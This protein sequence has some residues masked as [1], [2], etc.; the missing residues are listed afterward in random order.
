LDFVGV[1]VVVWISFL[2]DLSFGNLSLV[3]GLEGVG[4]EIESL[5]LWPCFDS[6]VVAL[7]LVVS[8]IFLL[9]LITLVSEIVREWPL[10]GW[11]TSGFKSNFSISKF[12]SSVV[13]GLLACLV[14]VVTL[15][16]AVL[17]KSSFSL[18]SNFSSFGSV[19]SFFRF[20]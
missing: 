16:A 1:L 13:E 6:L 18:V 15:G 2:S 9:I 8:S 11:V 17:F 4:F 14:F 20:L 10:A 5:F 7:V 3:V 12:N 19:L